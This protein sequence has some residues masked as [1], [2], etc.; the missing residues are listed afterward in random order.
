MRDL[1]RHQTLIKVSYFYP[2]RTKK[3][4]AYVPE[5]L[6]TQAKKHLYKFIY[7][8]SP[9]YKPIVEYIRSNPNLTLSKI[10]YNVMKIGY[11][12]S[13]NRLRDIIA[14]CDLKIADG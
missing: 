3:V 12:P 1:V 2:M 5:E 14:T 9:E 13:R 6:F 11:F 7:E 8:E 10:K 4:Q